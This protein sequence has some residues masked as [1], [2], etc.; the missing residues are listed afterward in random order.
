MQIPTT[1][2]PAKTGA[3]P[4]AFLITTILVA[5]ATAGCLHFGNDD[6]SETSDDDD[7]R[8]FPRDNEPRLTT[9]LEGPEDAWAGTNV[10]FDAT[11]SSAMHAQIV[12]WKFDLGDGTLLELEGDAEPRIEH[13]YTSG[14]VY[15]VNL[16]IEAQAE[17][18]DDNATNGAS[19]LDDGEVGGNATRNG[20]TVTETTSL[21]IAVHERFNIEETELDAG[22]SSTTSEDH[23]VAVNEGASNFTANLSVENP[24]LL[25][26]AEGTLRMLD[27]DGET[28]AEETFSIGSGGEETLTLSGTFNAT[29]T[30]TLEVELDS[31]EIAY[32]GTIDVTYEAAGKAGTGEAD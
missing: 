30:H 14:G 25:L 16:T 18:S 5:T 7:P 4:L 27:A 28:I 8:F 6:E 15:T 26:D 1:K 20:E 11:G 17:T 23:L 10:T 24:G 21:Q 12:A 31:G 22:L 29:G 13:N 9:S 32:E 2:T 19:A 3:R